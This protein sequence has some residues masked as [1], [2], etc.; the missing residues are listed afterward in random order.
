VIENGAHKEDAMPEPPT[1]A[2]RVTR[3]EETIAHQDHL[4]AQLSELV[5]AM[6]TEHDKAVARMGRQLAQFDARLEAPPADS[7]A[8]E[9]PP[10]Y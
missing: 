1:L 8:D 6:R 5:D 7:L 9:K 4:I 3:L 2:D 10:H